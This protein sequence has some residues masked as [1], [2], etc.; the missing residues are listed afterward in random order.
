MGL[1][2]C[3]RSAEE[4]HL[5]PVYDLTKVRGKV[6]STFGGNEVPEPRSHQPRRARV[7]THI[8]VVGH[9]HMRTH[10]EAAVF[11][12]FMELLSCKPRSEHRGACRSPALPTNLLEQGLAGFLL[13]CFFQLPLGRHLGYKVKASPCGLPQALSRRSELGVPQEDSLRLG[14]PGVL[15][16]LSILP[17]APSATPSSHSPWL[18]SLEAPGI[19]QHTHSPQGLLGKLLPS[20]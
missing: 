7:H 6:P 12:L 15:L 4:C 20:L 3:E 9:A 18:L 14:E 17:A 1:V 13:S 19:P 10:T 11:L 16:G 8:P 2:C 5:G